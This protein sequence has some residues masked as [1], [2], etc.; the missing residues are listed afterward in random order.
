MLKKIKNKLRLRRALRKEQLQ[1]IPTH[2]DDVIFEWKA[3][4]YLQYHKGNKWFVVFS[5]IVGL[6]G[7][8][9]LVMKDYLFATAILLFGVVYC[10]THRDKPEEVSIGL[11]KLGIKIGD[12]V[13]PYEQIK[14]FWIIY[15]PPYV[16]TINFRLAKKFLPDIEIY[17]HGQNPSQLRE[18]LGHRIPE[19]VNR[20]ETFTETLIRL[21]RL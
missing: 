10:M 12:R 19:W 15:N 1:K 3:P 21:M 14:A 18:F 2:F 17:L 20:Q 4:E 7:M 6:F 16:Q 5:L 11:S 13:Y 8:Y 9:A